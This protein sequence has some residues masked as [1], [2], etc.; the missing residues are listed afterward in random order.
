ML[1]DR[2][3]IPLP[4]NHQPETYPVDAQVLADRV[5]NNTGFAAKYYTL[6]DSLWCDLDV[7]DA[8]IAPKLATTIK[9]VSPQISP[10]F[11]DG[12]GRVWNDVITHIALT[13]R[14]RFID[15][16][17]FGTDPNSLAALLS[18]DDSSENI[19]L[20]MDCML[21]DDDEEQNVHN[22]YAKYANKHGKDENAWWK[23]PADIKDSGGMA[24]T[25][26]HPPEGIPFKEHEDFHHEMAKH[27]LDAFKKHEAVHSDDKQ[28]NFK[29]KSAGARADEHAKALSYHL[30]KKFDARHGAGEL[31]NKVSHEMYG[32]MTGEYGRPTPGMMVGVDHDRYQE[33]LLRR[34]HLAGQTEPSDMSDDSSS[35]PFLIGFL[36]KNGCLPYRLSEEYDDD[37]EPLTYN[38]SYHPRLSHAHI[39]ADRNL[40]EVEGNK[41]MRDIHSH[42]ENRAAY[43]AKKIMSLRR[44]VP[45]RGTAEDRKHHEKMFLEHKDIADAIAKVHPELIADKK[46]FEQQEHGLSDDIQMSSDVGKKMV[47]D[48]PKEAW[49][50][51]PT[52]SDHESI[53][54]Q[55]VIGPRLWKGTHHTGK[56]AYRTAPQHKD[57]VPMFKKTSAI[58]PMQMQSAKTIYVHPHADV[59]HPSDLK[60]FHEEMAKR[61]EILKHTYKHHSPGGD[62]GPIGGVYPH[63]DREHELSELYHKHMA[64]IHGH[65]AGLIDYFV[66]R[67]GDNGSKYYKKSRYGK[68]LSGA[69]KQPEMVE[70]F[71]E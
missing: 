46:F 47:D 33:S 51:H 8:D 3:N 7:T 11:V 38:K 24:I 19:C 66:G 67:K 34:K 2:L 15:Q 21:G 31:S 25:I 49:T 5:K 1:A 41:A 35:S 65:N 27:H 69:S 70:S 40:K 16:K 4:L 17:P 50:S 62:R 42:H 68:H 9:Y 64:G 63:I 55:A 60:A 22:I 20:S 54:R 44:Q 58:P 13:P 61:H 29:R 18:D 23:E 30:T 39:L 52:E 45:Y 12:R 36:D 10:K 6:G 71:V 43:H 28:S 26:A 48:L 32:H 59:L 14:P 56:T 57:D 53:L 37:E